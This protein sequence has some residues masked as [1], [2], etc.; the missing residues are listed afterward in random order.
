MRYAWMMFVVALVA[1]L[2]MPVWGQPLYRSIPGS[3]NGFSQSQITNTTAS[4][5]NTSTAI[6]LVAPSR[7]IQVT[8]G[9]TT[10][11]ICYVD[12]AGNP[13]TTADYAV[14]QSGA[15]GTVTYEGE[16]ISTFN[17]IGATAAGT[18]SVVAY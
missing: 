14:N 10:P 3:S 15:A 13:A 12:F 7:H 8:V 9:G 5:A 11:A 1:T 6:N 4:V 2:M 17:Y 16:P 18:I